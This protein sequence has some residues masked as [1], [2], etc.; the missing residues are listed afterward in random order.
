MDGAKLI[1]SHIASKPNEKNL[2]LIDKLDIDV[3]FIYFFYLYI[4]FFLYLG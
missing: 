1:Y 4:F 2:K 3:I